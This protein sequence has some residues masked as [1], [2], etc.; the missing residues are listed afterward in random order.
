MGKNVPLTPLQSSIV[1]CRS[2][3]R[4]AEQ[5]E[6]A[7]R[8][9]DAGACARGLR[10]GRSCRGPSGARVH[11]PGPLHCRHLGISPDQPWPKSQ[12]SSYTNSKYGNE[13]SFSSNSVSSSWM[14]SA[15]LPTRTMNLSIVQATRPRGTW[16]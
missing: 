3:P 1:E 7:F 15:H 11:R 10:A 13:N 8:R 16:V 4:A 2:S 12:C 14:G 9:S 5:G 6:A